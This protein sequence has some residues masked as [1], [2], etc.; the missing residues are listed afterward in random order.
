MGLVKEKVL[1]LLTTSAESLFMTRLPRSTNVWSSQSWCFTAALLPTLLLSM[2][3]H[4]AP[5]LPN[6]GSILRGQRQDTTPE[7]PSRG[8][9]L[10]K[11]E[12][13]PTPEDVIQESADQQGERFLVQGFRITQSNTFSDAEL[14]VVV[15]EF[16]GQVT[17][18]KELNR[19]ANL[20]TRY[21]RAR[22]YFVASAYLPA[23]EVTDGVVEIKVLEGSLEGVEVYSSQ[24]VNRRL[25]PS[26][27]KAVLRD[28]VPS[29]GAIRESDVERGLLLLNEFSGINARG[30]LGPGSSLGTTQLTAQIQ[31]GSL[32]KGDIGFDNFG[33]PS[34]GENRVNGSFSL[35]D[36]SGSGDRVN[37]QMTRSSYTSYWQLSYVRPVG[38]SGLKLGASASGSDF[39]LCCQFSALD[40]RGFS[41]VYTLNAKYPFLL[42]SNR[43]LAGNVIFEDKRL[44]NKSF[45][46]LTSDSRI[47]SI[48][49]GLDGNHSDSLGRS[50]S[51]YA[52]FLGLGHHELAGP[53]QAVS[54]DR[55]T[56]RTA[57]Y[58]GKLNF[59]LSQT[60]SINDDWSLLGSFNGQLAGSNLPSAEQFS[61]GGYSGV[62]AYSDG[63]VSGDDGSVLTLELK[64]SLSPWLS[65]S[66]F[67]DHGEIRQHHKPWPGWQLPGSTEPNSYRLNDY[68]FSIDWSI[69]PGNMLVNVTV[70]RALGGNPGAGPGSIGSAGSNGKSRFWVQA[71]KYF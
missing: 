57:G 1:K 46:G 6:A 2:A 49:M 66:A 32:I 68:G 55:V 40:I 60:Q 65:L 33:S 15:K 50:S 47:R 25:R 39:R 45:F 48:T 37:V 28:A 9:N 54:V 61:L 8:T 41:D 42:E 52:V 13:I 30:T 7:R 23:Q 31:E 24:S 44:V 56:A 3:V 63:E 70:A 29:S 64:R 71:I 34:T 20:I 53:E 12:N 17:S 58:F 10:L 4:A 36:P 59:S 27:A 62:R 11:I 22:G 21:Y 35:R 16:V 51:S 5:T 67:I 14:Q 26:V 69:N 38:T 18:I 43:S 19:A